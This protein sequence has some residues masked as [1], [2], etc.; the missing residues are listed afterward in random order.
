VRASGQVKTFVDGTQLGSDVANSGDI[1][2]ASG[3][4][5]GRNSTGSLY[6]PGWLD[7]I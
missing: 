7:E 6:F 3:L 1:T 5:I 4:Q 2:Y